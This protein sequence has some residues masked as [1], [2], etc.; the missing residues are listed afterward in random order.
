MR[1]VAIACVFAFLTAGSARAQS[2]DHEGRNAT[3]ALVGAGAIVLGTVIAAK[4]GD[5]TTITSGAGVTTTS[6]FS[7]TQLGIGLGM[8][9]VGG[10]LLWDGLRTH[11]DR[12]PSTSVGVSVGKRTGLFVRK[13]W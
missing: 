5:S 1:A 6:S 9:G 3:K 10:F 11:P 13:R 12:Y 4:S 7:A 2:R 8:A